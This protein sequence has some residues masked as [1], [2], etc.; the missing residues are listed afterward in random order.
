MKNLFFL[1][2]LSVFQLG[3]QEA[4]SPIVKDCEKATD[5]KACSIEKWAEFEKS[6]QATLEAS[7]GFA[8]A[9]SLYLKFTVSDKGKV[10]IEESFAMISKVTLLSVEGVLKEK[11]V[12]LKPTSGSETYVWVWNMVL[13]DNF[14]YYESFYEVRSYPEMIECKSFNSTGRR[15]CSDYILYKTK[16]ELLDEGVN[17]HA[18]FKVY[19][20]EGQVVAIEAVQMPV[21]KTMADRVVLSAN[22]MMVKMATESSRKRSDEFYA[23]MDFEFTGDSLKRW[24]MRM[25]RLDY[26]KGIKSPTPFLKEVLDIQSAVFSKQKE[27]GNRFL[28]GQLAEIDFDTKE[29]FR[30][31]SFVYSLDSIKN[32]KYE[33]G[34]TLGTEG[35]N[36][37]IV[38]HKPLFKGCAEF[39]GDN[40]S[41]EKC[42]NRGI[43][44][45][46]AKNFIFSETARRKGIQGK[47]YTSFVIEKDGEVSNVS[48]VRGVHQLLDLEC[49]RVISEIPEMDS[50]AVQRGKP[51]R[52]SFTMPINAKLQ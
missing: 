18:R 4:I 30:M 50:P 38:E 26:L 49:I 7:S 19:F 47:V 13:P 5:P 51:V 24:K 8:I 11:G 44:T 1:F 48:I 32:Y 33:E 22:E 46:V 3:A 31:G 15:G 17:E 34:D 40:E 20:K 27:V 6:L 16:E 28:M 23:Y 25:E 37:E 36:F 41:A 35:L 42:F 21:S 2:A 39:K 29:Q 10:K 45:H 12:E 52:I 14:S 9:D 43:S